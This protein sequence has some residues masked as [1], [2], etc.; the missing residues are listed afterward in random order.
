MMK[1]IQFTKGDAG[2]M[3]LGET[4]KPVAKLGE[5]LIKVVASAVNRADTLQR[6]GSY[7]PGPGISP[8]LGLEVAGT[9]EEV[10][11]DNQSW[12]KGDRVMA[13][14]SGGGYA[15]YIAVK[16]SHVLSVPPNLGLVEA[17]GVPEV[18]CT[19]Y[20]ILLTIGKLC[21]GESV[22][23]HAGTSGV[24]L[25]AIQLAKMTKAKNIII[26]CGSNE[27]CQMGLKM[28]A[29]VAINYKEADF[30]EKTLEITNGKGVDVI[31][32]CI[33][34]SYCEKNAECLALDARWV[35]YGLM[36]GANIQ[37]D[38]LAKLMRKRASLIG[39]LLRSRSDDYKD[40]LIDSV[41]KHVLPG[42]E[43]GKLK[44]IIDSIFD[45]KDV[46]DAHRRMEANSNIGKIVL[47]VINE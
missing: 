3:S 39:T 7:N 32:D 41:R 13:L 11:D 34:A 45:L 46:S 6:K 12:K 4:N 5:V 14:V 2:N 9:I 24:G 33:G 10:A 23:I 18:W 19:A 38:L 1:A 44:P 29:T 40:D 47:K 21:E 35:L 31:L 20:Q 22:L 36:G 16:S 17:G 37:G 28:G 15:E 43:S 25:A 27:K 30:K 42:I 8:I 26:T